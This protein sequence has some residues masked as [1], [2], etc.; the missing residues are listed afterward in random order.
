[1]RVSVTPGRY[2]V[3]V[4]GGVDSVVLLDLLSK[5]PG[6]ELVVAHF[7]HGIRPDSREDRTLVE[8]LSQKYR[9]TF[10]YEEGKL[11]A[12]VSENQAREA[13]YRFLQRIRKKTHA[14]AIITAHHADD[15]VETMAFNVLRGT[16]RKGMSSLQSGEVIRPLLPYSKAEIVAYARKHNLRWREDSTNTDTTFARNWLRHKV[17]P[18]LSS[19]EL[20]ALKQQ[21]ETAASSNKEVDA[22]VSRQL[23]GLETEAGL[24]RRS[25]IALPHIV[26]AEVMAAWLRQQHIKPI[27]HKL[28]DIAVVSVKTLPPGKSIDLD[29]DHCLVLATDTMQIVKAA[30]WKSSHT[31]V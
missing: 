9:L 18:Q 8:T 6:L 1:M 21:Y 24:D 19:K 29:K 22:L 3:A 25:F 27:H 28:I 4:S 11:G 10:E 13:R 23:A 12:G 5:L 31:S 7:D 17:L 14:Q 26:A 30:L 16:K 20:Q 15:A 2:V